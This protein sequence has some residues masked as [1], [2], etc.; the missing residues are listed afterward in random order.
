MLHLTVLEALYIYDSEH[1]DLTGGDTHDLDL[2]LQILV[3]E[4]L[5]KLEV[6]PKWLIGSANTLKQLFIN[7][8]LNFEGIAKV[9]ANFEITSYIGDHWLKWVI[10]STR[11][12]SSYENIKKTKD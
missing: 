10:I 2:R 12:D 11:G 9:Y 7:N 3:I 1:M 6:L 8:C 4:T 5:P